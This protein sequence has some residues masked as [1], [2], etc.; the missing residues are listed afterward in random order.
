MIYLRLRQAAELVNHKPVE[1]LYRL[2]QLH[3]R[4]WRR[5]KFIA[6]ERHPLLRS[7]FPNEVR[8]MSTDCVFRY[9]NVG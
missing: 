9:S 2:E 8:L 5:K 1:R 4:S 3:M 6:A 7:A